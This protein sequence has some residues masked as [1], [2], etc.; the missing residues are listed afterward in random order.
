MPTARILN[1]QPESVQH[2]MPTPRNQ[3]KSRLTLFDEDAPQPDKISVFTDAQDRVPDLDESDDNP[4]VG[5]RKKTVK[6][7]PRSTRAKALSPAHHDEDED[8]AMEEAV[9]NQKGLIY[10]L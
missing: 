1:F 4:F 2:V 6:T 9:R 10:V 7:A 8:A 5:P 3:R